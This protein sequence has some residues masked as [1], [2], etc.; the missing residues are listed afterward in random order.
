MKAL[1]KGRHITIIQ[2]DAHADTIDSFR[3]D[4]FNHAC[5]MARA[6]GM[7]DIV[8]VG[9]RSM[10][11]TEWDTIDRKRL[12]LARQVLGNDRW[13]EEA[14]RL[15]GEEVYVTIDCD[16]F[17]PSIIPSGTPE[18]G[19]LGWYDVMDFLHLVAKARRVIGFDITELCPR[20]TD[21]AP[22]FLA[23][24]LIYSFLSEI[25]IYRD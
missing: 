5:V 8:Q 20:E 17:D 15:I 23:A 16:V 3:K 7:G 11:K 9:I 6:A 10:D 2:F 1:S 4:G 25:F 21:K 22:D 18:P 12:F 19:G 13:M 24:K 14:I